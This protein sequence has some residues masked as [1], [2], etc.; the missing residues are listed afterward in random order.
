MKQP[1]TISYRL[2]VLSS[3]MAEALKNVGNFK[4]IFRLHH[5]EQWLSPRRVMFIGNS[6]SDKKLGLLYVV[7]Q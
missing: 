4:S 6:V 1:V 5:C 7:R 2:P 3:S